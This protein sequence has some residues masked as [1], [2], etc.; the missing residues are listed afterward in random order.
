MVGDG[1]LSTPIGARWED[2]RLVSSIVGPS[3]S[4]NREAC[5]AFGWA[6]TVDGLV[7]GTNDGDRIM[8]SK[9]VDINKLSGEQLVS[10]R[11]VFNFPVLEGRIC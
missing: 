7:L 6:G 4:D 9:V 1:R 2:P 10:I 3:E 5:A 8:L 11:R